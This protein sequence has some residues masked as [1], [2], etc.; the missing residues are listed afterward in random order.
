MMQDLHVMF[1]TKFIN[2]KKRYEQT[3][4]YLG[5]ISNDIEEIKNK[6]KEI[7]SSDNNI[8]ICKIFKLCNSIDSITIDALEYFEN[9][10]NLL[11]NVK[12]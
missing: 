8:V 4:V 3:G 1:Y 11:N 7:A 2:N 12:E 6:G 9:F 10:G 5:Y